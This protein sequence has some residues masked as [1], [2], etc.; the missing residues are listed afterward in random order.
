MPKRVTE[1]H[2]PT[3]DD[4]LALLV[5]ELASVQAENRALRAQLDGCVRQPEA[6]GEQERGYSRAM[7]AALKNFDQL[8][9]E[10]RVD[11]R[12]VAGLFGCS[13]A[14]VWRRVAAG[15]FP[16]PERIVGTTRWPVAT[17]RSVRAGWSADRDMDHTERR[18]DRPKPKPNASKRK[19]VLTKVEP[20]AIGGA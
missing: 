5:C 9:D 6:R 3:P 15:I 1:N 2:A 18:V 7:P 12:V 17:L 4:A 14:T 19:H 16:E 11:V 10:A 20:S 13:V 8:P